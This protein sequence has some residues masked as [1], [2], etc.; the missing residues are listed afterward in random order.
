M[1]EQFD[2][3]LKLALKLVWRNLQT[4]FPKDLVGVGGEDFRHS[5]LA[6]F[7]VDERLKAKLSLVLEVL[8]V[9][10]AVA[11]D[12]SEFVLDFDQFVDDLTLRKDL[13]HVHG[14]AFC[15]S[16]LNLL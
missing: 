14:F 16:E 10:E 8:I 7:E 5:K 2:D 11:H 13:L 6:D 15:I 4:V 1:R 3:L 12:V 9:V